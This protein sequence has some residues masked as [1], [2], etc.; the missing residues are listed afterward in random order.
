MLRLVG[1][2]VV[3]LVCGS[4][5]ALAADPPPLLTDLSKLSLH[6][7]GTE[8]LDRIQNEGDEEALTPL[9]GGKLVVVTLGGQAPDPCRIALHA[10]E[11]SA[12]FERAT[13]GSIGEKEVETRV[14]QS[15]AI[16]FNNDGRW[17]IA[18]HPR[19]TRT[20]GINPG[21]AQCTQYLW[22][23]SPVTIQVVFELGEA[24]EQFALRYPAAIGDAVPM[25]K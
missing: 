22:T 9:M 15:L 21:E 18:G 8:L 23:P 20:G 2:C 10:R 12:V 13:M 6:V 1:S 16:R 24:L 14:V 7:T 25:P 17:C 3:A 5:V 4:S 19:P 11:F